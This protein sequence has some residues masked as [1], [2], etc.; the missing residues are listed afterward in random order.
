[1]AF[2]GGSGSR[3]PDYFRMPANQPICGLPFPGHPWHGSA[4]PALVTATAGGAE[5]WKAQAT[6]AQARMTPA[7]RRNRRSRQRLRRSSTCSS[8]C[9]SGSGCGPLRLSVGDEQLGS[10]V[11]DGFADWRGGA[12]LGDPGHV[13]IVDRL[14]FNEQLKQSL[15]SGR[16]LALLFRRMVPKPQDAALP[17]RTARLSG[18]DRYGHR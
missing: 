18:Q 9:S 17:A 7:E 11:L 5:T 8:G 6:G 2:R 1:M 10:D 13:A 15:P 4:P 14:T 16:S 12:G 3:M